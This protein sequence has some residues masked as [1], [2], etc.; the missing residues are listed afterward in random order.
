MKTR[1]L[2]ILTCT[3]IA[4]PLILLALLL[5]NGARLGWLDVLLLGPGNFVAQLFVSEGSPGHR[6][7]W[8][9]Y[10]SFGLN[11]LFLWVVLLIL[12]FLIEKLI[13]RRKKHA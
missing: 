5:D 8:F 2:L 1:R 10:V 3:G 11:L 7:L 13:T 12:A 4:S 9:F 6:P